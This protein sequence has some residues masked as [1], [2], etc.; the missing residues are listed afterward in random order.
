MKWQCLLVK[1]VKIVVMPM[2]LRLSQ[3]W[4]FEEQLQIT[5]AG[6]IRSVNGCMNMCFSREIEAVAM[7]DTKALFCAVR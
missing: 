2:E 6:A 1:N 5:G 3:T 7:H 4:S